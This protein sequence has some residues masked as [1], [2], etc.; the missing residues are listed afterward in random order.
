MEKRKTELVRV[1]LYKQYAGRCDYYF[2]TLK[3]IYRTLPTEVVGICYQALVN[4]KFNEKRFYANQ[5]C[6]MDIITVD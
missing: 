3:G 2:K 6:T 4:Y 1:R 5:F